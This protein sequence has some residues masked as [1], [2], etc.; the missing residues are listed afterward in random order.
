MTCQKSL[1]VCVCAK[2]Y[3]HNSFNFVTLIREHIVWWKRNFETE[4]V[5]QTIGEGVCSDVKTKNGVLY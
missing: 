3:M 5:G 2:T 1:T 4:G